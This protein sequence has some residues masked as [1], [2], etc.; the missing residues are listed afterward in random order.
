MGKRGPWLTTARLS[1]AGG[2]KLSPRRGPSSDRCP[3]SRGSAERCK[4]RGPGTQLWDAQQ[5]LFPPW[6]CWASRRLEILLKR[7][8]KQGAQPQGFLVSYP[9]P[10]P[11]LDMGKDEAWDDSGELLSSVLSHGECQGDLTTL[12]TSDWKRPFRGQCVYLG[13]HLQ[14]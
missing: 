5:V 9:F 6:A 4:G 14:R 13:I 2:S 12:D 10:Q 8:V 11:W 1:S 3:S 7:N